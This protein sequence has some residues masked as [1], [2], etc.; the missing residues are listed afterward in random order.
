MGYPLGAAGSFNDLTCTSG[1]GAGTT[2]LIQRT[3]ARSIQIGDS[4][5]S[6]RYGQVYIG[7]YQGEKVAVKKFTSWDE[8]SWFREAE[9]YRTVLLRHENIL[10]FF[11]SDM[12]SNNGVTELW[13]ITE[14]HAHGSLYDYLHVKAISQETMLK[15]SMSICSGLSHLHTELFGTQSKPA[16]AH[17]DMKSKNILV[18]SNLTCCIADFGLAVIKESVNTVNVPANPKQGTKRYMSPEILSEAINMLNF[19][20]FKQADVYA[21]GLVLW[22]LCKL[23]RSSA[24]VC[25]CVCVCVCMHVCVCKGVCASIRYVSVYNYVV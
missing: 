19:E 20:S 15:M 21:V 7:R 25:V 8:K 2:W 12:V 9:I 5:G 14:Y 4:I 18:K 23:C 17:R 11:A 6:G 24:G 1:S 16:M 13:L 10:G 22:E 3:I